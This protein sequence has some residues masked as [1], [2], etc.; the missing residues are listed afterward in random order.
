MLSHLIVYLRGRKLG[1]RSR[2]EHEKAYEINVAGETHQLYHSGF[3]SAWITELGIT[4]KTII[5]LGGYDGGDA[6]RFQHD[7]PDCR[8]IS[9]E[10]DPQR[11]E[12][13]RQNLSEINAEALNIAACDTDGP[14]EWFASTIDGV[15]EA[16]ARSI[17]IPMPTRK[18]S[19]LLIR[20]ASRKWLPGSGF[21]RF[22]PRMA[23]IRLIFCIWMLRGQSIL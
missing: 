9:V 4:P 10:A 6:W 2:P 3:N 15:R 21:R 19:R 11:F 17:A 5:D 14:I 20:W 23:S 13:V 18:N 12:I 1:L 22:V 8:V 16:R 7:F